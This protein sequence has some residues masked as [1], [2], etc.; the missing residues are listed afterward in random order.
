MG[1]IVSKGKYAPAGSFHGTKI[2]QN[3][4]L[5]DLLKKWD[6]EDVV[7][8]GIMLIADGKEVTTAYDQEYDKWT[9]T[10]KVTGDTAVVMKTTAHGWLHLRLTATH[11]FQMDVS[12][13]SH[14]L[15]GQ[16]VASSSKKF[17]CQDVEAALAY[18][19]S[20]MYSEGTVHEFSSFA[21]LV[22]EE[23]SGIYCEGVRQ[24]GSPLDTKKAPLEKHQAAGCIGVKNSGSDAD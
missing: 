3:K 14:R 11:G 4:G 19:S 8:S 10:E 16:M 21:K 12:N 13:P 1:G 22:F 18:Q 20:I 6:K 24:G 5:Q 15:Q 7:F 2:H 17:K 23:V 9:T